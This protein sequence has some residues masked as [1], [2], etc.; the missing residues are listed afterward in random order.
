MF[1]RFSLKANVLILSFIFNVL[2]ALNSAGVVSFVRN[3]FV[4]NASEVEEFISKLVA[5]SDMRFS[6]A[7]LVSETKEIEQ[8]NFKTSTELRPH[9]KVIPTYKATFEINRNDLA[10]AINN[11]DEAEIL[12]KM[13]SNWQEVKPFLDNYLKEIENAAELKPDEIAKEVKKAQLSSSIDKVLDSLNELQD[14][15]SI[16]VENLAKQNQQV[17]YTI[18]KFLLIC[19]FLFCF[20][21]AFV[22]RFFATTLSNSLDG[23]STE[24]NESV[25]NLVTLSMRI[26]ETANLGNENASL[27]ENRVYQ[28]NEAL[29]KI[30]KMSQQTSNLSSNS[31]AISTDSKEIS[32]RGQDSFVAVTTSIQDIS[33]SN[34]SL[35]QEIDAGNTK[36]E[37]IAGMIGEINEK[38]NVINDIVFQ[39]KLLSFNASIE[40]A[41]SS[42]GSSFMV[43]ADEVG[44]LAMMSG[45]AAKEIFS[46]LQDGLDKI[47]QLI[48]S[49]KENART[50]I[51]SS[52]LNIKNG[53]STSKECAEVLNNLGRNVEGIS[54][55]LVDIAASS[56]NQSDEISSVLI[57]SSEINEITRKNLGISKDSIKISEELQKLSVFINQNIASLDNHIKGKST[58]AS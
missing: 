43:V 48:A 17:L 42:N 11:S 52:A 15:Q 38:I 31:L 23:L 51:S 4:K 28:A 14:K 55:T 35:L 12:K 54:D 39:T 25:H 50:L 6:L 2:F 13:S 9:L 8:G 37:N 30:N 26:R 29:E 45:E 49:S 20:I 36:L 34:R 47:T 41:R 53:I 33:E 22:G 3:S 32:T 18:Y 44:K 46:L 21:T 57:L 5:I 7:K 27:Q 24:L 10:K 1:T 58:R 40:A 19:F 56:Q 16:G